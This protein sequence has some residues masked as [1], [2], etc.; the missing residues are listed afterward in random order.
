MEEN[1]II[2]EFIPET[3]EEAAASRKQS[4]Q[5]ARNWA[6]LQARILEIGEKYRGKVICIA[7]EELFVGDDIREAVGAQKPLTRMIREAS[8]G[9]F[10][11]KGT[12]GSML[13]YWT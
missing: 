3:P 13:C 8:F 7:G 11:R 5:F 10:P 6:W 4:E 12:R 2:M 1:R 9:A